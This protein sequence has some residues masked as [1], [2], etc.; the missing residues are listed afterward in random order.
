MYPPADERVSE[1]AILG[2]RRK[3][4]AGAT[5]CPSEA[6]RVVAPDTWRDHLEAVRATAAR[7]AEQGLLVVTQRVDPVELRSARGPVRLRLR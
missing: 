6:A 5:T 4:A 7:L 2:L 1:A 3:R